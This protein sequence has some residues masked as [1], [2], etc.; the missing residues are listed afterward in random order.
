MNNCKKG[1][2]KNNMKYIICRNKNY[3]SATIMFKVKVGSRNEINNIRGI[4][5][6]IEHML[7]KGTINKN[8]AKNIS[9]SLYKFGGEFNA[10]T[11]YEDTTYYTKIDYMHVKEGIEI[12][13]DMLF[14][15]LFK[16]DDIKSEKK[17]IISENKKDRSD[18]NRTLSRL[19]DALI[20]NKTSFEYDI[21]GYDKDIIKF[22]RDNIIDYF[23][24]F[25]NPDNITVAICGNYKENDKL[26][27]ELLNKYFGKKKKNKKSIKKYNLVKY[28]NFINI[29]KNFRYKNIIKKYSQAYVSIG[30]PCYN[31]KDKKK[32]TMDI[33]SNILGGN[34]SSR[35][36]IKVREE[37]SLVY[38][39]NTYYDEY[40]DIGLF[41]INFGTFEDIKSILKCINIVLSELKDLKSNKISIEELKNNKNYV[42]GNFVLSLED[43]STIAHHNI[44]NLVYNNKLISVEDIKINLDKK[45]INKIIKVSDEIFVKNRC[46]IAIISKYKIKKNLIQNIVKK[47][48]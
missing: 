43:T 31:T 37:K 33:I 2:L 25:Y 10:S 39:I 9:N 34:M 42:F 22:K 6:F 47:Y 3:K 30:F 35:L 38:N 44:D 14:N 21:G 15:S 5:H 12:L 20:F 17:V 1:N 13:S 29:Q 24:K 4:S 40:S 27:I 26:I 19:I 32:Y 11:G 41:T 7:F 16:D 18:P 8:T 28:N 45:N 46:N 23:N 36:F 48:L